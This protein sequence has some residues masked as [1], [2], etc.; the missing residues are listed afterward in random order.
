MGGILY[1]PGLKKSGK[2]AGIITLALAAGAGTIFLV[3]PKGK[4]P[5]IKNSIAKENN[6]ESNTENNSTGNNAIPDYNVNMDGCGTGT[7]NL[8][9]AGANSLKTGSPDK[10]AAIHADGNSF[11]F[12]DMDTII[13]FPGNK[14]WIKEPEA[15]TDGNTGIINYYDGVAETKAT[16]RFGEK[17]QEGILDFKL[18]TDIEPDEYWSYFPVKGEG[19]K[20]M[21]IWTSLPFKNS[22]NTT[23]LSWECNNMQF[24]MYANFPSRPGKDG[25][26]KT[27]GWTVL[28]K[29]AAYSVENLVQ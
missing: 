2:W 15:Y 26:D 6:I 24:Y 14:N 12:K 23:L 20:L 25:E 3:N 4:E 27:S 22:I 5:G 29:L 1:M 7:G 28:A 8:N 9:E 21:K 19:E 10:K 17:G 13:K 18:D 11:Y 16:F